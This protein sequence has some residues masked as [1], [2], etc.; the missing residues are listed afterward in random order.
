VLLLIVSLSWM[1]IVDLTPASQRPY[2]G[3]SSTNSELQLAI[4][5]NGLDRLLGMGSHSQTGSSG[6]TSTSRAGFTA[7]ENGSSGVFRLWNEQLGGQVSWLLVLALLGLVAAAWQTRRR[8]PLDRQ[9]QALVLWG[10]WLLTAGIFFSVAGFYHTYYLTMLAPA[11]CALFGIGVL[12]LWR[13]YRRQ[14]WQGWLLPIALV[15]TAV[16][17]A[18]ILSN[19]AIW[20]TVLT[21]VVVGLCLVAALMLT[22]ARL[23]LPLHLPTTLRTPA[24]AL[25]VLVLLL[26]PTVWSAFSVM[27]APNGSLPTAGP[28]SLNASGLRAGLSGT[29]KGGFGFPDRGNG[30]S[31]SILEL[32]ARNPQLE[33]YLLSH[34]GSTR[35]LVATQSAMTAESIILDTGQP[36][37]ALGGFTGG[38]PILT[39]RQLASLVSQNT[40]RFFLLQDTSSLPGGGGGSSGI[41]RQNSQLTQWVQQSCKVVPQQLWSSGQNQSP[42]PSSSN[43]QQPGSG[44]SGQQLYDCSGVH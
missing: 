21:L 36:V 41:T 15:A 6:S 19:Y 42:V 16:V 4:G 40:V 5:Y 26:A 39:T 32:S 13:D 43:G 27:Q 37:M 8:L 25:G 14:G 3:S 18:T 29:K 7:G 31:S 24:V 44:M 10:M 1:V 11:I 20:S 38:D 30:G 35:Y 34:Q 23:K 12:A 9:Q 33:Q 2:V 28:P 22:L 17:Q